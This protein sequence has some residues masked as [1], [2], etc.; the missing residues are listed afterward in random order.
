LPVN[1]Q[2]TYASTGAPEYGTAVAQINP[3]AFEDEKLTAKGVKIGVI[4]AG[5]YLANDSELLKNIFS[6]NRIKFFR[7]FVSPKKEKF[8][9]ESE[10]SQDEHGTNVME[11]IAGEIKGESKT[12]FATDAEFY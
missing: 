10:T 7:D 4:D 11:M 5:F 8:F 6:E 2:F 9:E 3:S 12:G 1:L